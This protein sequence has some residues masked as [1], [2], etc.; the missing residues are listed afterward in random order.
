MYM[1]DTGQQ[2]I[3]HPI[4]EAVHAHA[5]EISIPESHDNEQVTAI[6][7]EAGKGDLHAHFFNRSGVYV[8]FLNH[9]DEQKVYVGQATNL[10]SRALNKARLKRESVSR[11]L[12]FSTKRKHQF[13][14]A[15]IQHLEYYVLRRLNNSN[16]LVKNS[17]SV[18]PSIGSKKL[19]SGVED[20]FT[21]MDY[22]LQGRFEGVFDNA[23]PI[24]FDVEI[25]LRER[26][27]A[28]HY[29][30]A[31]ARFNRTTKRVQII[32]DKT[33]ASH[34]RWMVP[35]TYQGV[36]TNMISTGLLKLQPTKYGKHCHDGYV[37]TSDLV[38]MNISEATTI[39]LNQPQASNEWYVVETGERL[40]DSE[41][42]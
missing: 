42:W 3:Y 25:E 11:V 28:K 13:N 16:K 22:Y 17:Q 19:T 30:I 24:G 36:K 7:K 2:V 18:S 1:T 35:K 20:W 8:Y 34:G 37:F 21:S 39:I 38:L 15:E 6:L 40:Q 4:D 29:C 33:V 32:A 41:Y 10:E 12:L 5:L 31:K 27:N 14:E 9:N 23:D 26:D